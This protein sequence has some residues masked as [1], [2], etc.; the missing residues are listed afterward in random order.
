MGNP[1]QRWTAEEE[2][3]LRAGIA[4]HGT[5][6]WSTILKD[7][8][9]GQILYS[10]SNVDLKDKWRNI[11]VIS[12]GR[13]PRERATVTMKKNRQTPKSNNTQMVPSSVVRDISDGILDAMPIAISAGPP[14]TTT[15]GKT[16][17]N[18]ANLILEAITN[19]KEANGCN[20]TAITMYI[21]DHYV[22]RADLKQLL[23][24]ELQR[25]TGTGILIKSKHNYR[26]APNSNPSEGRSSKSKLLCKG[27]QREPSRVNTGADI[28]HLNKPQT[29]SNL[30]KM[31]HMSSEE[32]AAA[33]V[34]AIAEAEAAT[35]K[36]E[37]AMR[38]AEAAEADAEYAQAVAEQLALA[39]ENGSSAMS[40][41]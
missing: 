28:K 40:V 16:E 1:K 31:V 2:S 15:P 27:R 25:M 18:M 5:G 6:K 24:G 32:A 14:P 41:R 3:A 9:F 30:A 34:Q 17:A 21:E 26:I 8:E 11:R 10:R 29:Y 33:A 37:E 12:S 35:Y 20:I 19:L 7:P 23:S 13:G 36:A 4:K 38:L 22:P 39:L